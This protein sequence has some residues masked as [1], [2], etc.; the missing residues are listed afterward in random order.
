[1]RM[2]Y[3]WMSTVDSEILVLWALNVPPSIPPAQ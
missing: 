2:K 1:M 3:M